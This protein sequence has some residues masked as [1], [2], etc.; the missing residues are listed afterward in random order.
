MLDTTIDRDEPKIVGG[1]EHPTEVLVE[2]N[3][4]GQFEWQPHCREWWY[5][6]Q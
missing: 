1:E 2:T 3:N 4:P 5:A 6:I